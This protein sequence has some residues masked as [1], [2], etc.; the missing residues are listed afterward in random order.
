MVQEMFKKPL[1]PTFPA[2]FTNVK[3]PEVVENI[4]PAAPQPEIIKDPPG[5]FARRM[6]CSQKLHYSNVV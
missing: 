6:L 3:M 4:P 2:T 5:R 1:K